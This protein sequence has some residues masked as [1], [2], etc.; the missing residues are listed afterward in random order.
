MLQVRHALR[1]RFKVATTVGFGPRF[2]HS[3]GQL[4]K[5][6]PDTGVFLQIVGDDPDEIE[7][8]GRTFTFGEPKHAR[9]L[10]DLESLRS[11]GRRVARTTNDELEEIER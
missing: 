3:T 11:K 2:L 4:H 5:G 1:D 7:I 8:P 9:A 6:G 10:G